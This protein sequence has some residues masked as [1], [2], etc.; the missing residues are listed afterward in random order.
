M[1]ESY[2]FKLIH[3]IKWSKKESNP[4]D[5]IRDKDVKRVGYSFSHNCGIDSDPNTINETDL[6]LQKKG[7]R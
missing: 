4:V 5:S 3:K 1:R 6:E 2:Y 7:I